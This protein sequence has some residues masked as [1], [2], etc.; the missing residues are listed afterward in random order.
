M[1]SVK[2]SRK[3]FLRVCVT[4]AAGGA[5]AA[6]QRVSPEDGTPPPVATAT[7][8]PSPV[9]T[10]T[11]AAGSDPEPAGEIILNGDGADAWTWVKRITGKTT[12]PLDC[13]ALAASVN[14]LEVE[15]VLEG[16]EISAEAPL[17]EGENRIVAFCRGAPGEVSSNPILIQ[18]RL[19]KVPVARIRI[20]ADGERVV[21]GGGESQPAEEGGPEII[22]HIWS[23]R[24]GNPGSLQLQGVSGLEGLALNGEVSSQTIAVVPP[25]VDGEYYLR[26]RVKDQAGRED[27]STIYFVVADG[28]PRIPDY[29]TENPAWVEGAIVYGVIP[30][31][32]GNPAFQA[33]ID[34]LDDLADL[35][36]NAIWLGPINVYPPDDYG[37]AVEDYFAPNPT[38][39]T[40]QD[41]HR[42]VQAAHARGIRVLM[43]FVPSHTSNTHPYFLDAEQRGPESNYWDF[44]ARDAQ[45]NYTYYFEY[46]HLPNLNYENPEVRR[47]IVEAFS[48]WVREFDI[49]GFRVD[50]A[51]AITERRPDF[52]PEWRR[53]LKRIKPDLLLL[54]EASARDPYYFDNGFDAA[55]DWTSAVGSWAWETVW[56]SYQHR[57]LSYNLDVALTNRPEGFH[58]DAL[59][60]RFINNNDTGERF[61]TRHGEGMARVATALVLTLP[62]IPL[63]YTGDEYGLEFEPY[64]ALNPLNFRERSP[65]LRA[66]HQQ[67]ISLRKALPSLRSR[68]WT[69]V[70]LNP[71]PQQVY[72]FVRYLEGQEQPVV[73]LLNFFEEPAE[74][75]FNLPEEFR[76]LSGRRLRDFLGTR[77]VQVSAQG[78]LRLTLPGLT[79]MVLAGEQEI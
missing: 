28:R 72:G 8:P 68:L 18:G 11:Q 36:V 77:T 38:Y 3:A 64:Q 12:G 62:G 53:E 39:G 34:R 22:D 78:G 45:G 76:A 31:L 42:L 50:F 43:D 67:L 2:L 57:L 58:P 52:W 4:A 79:A 29:D 44:Y 15:A 54:A 33:I 32:F 56:D 47:M 71:V 1:K 46:A 7:P 16:E 73:V 55:Y 70:E 66:Y 37:Y 65:G 69:P 30:F 48:Y 6:C 24:P 59:I 5:V 75:E 20:A 61:I 74:L 63:I 9:P 41:F 23:A 17:S 25:A 19:R 35:G 13:D 14:G 21:L 51:W 40:K 60:L 26:L 27:S 49:D 10:A